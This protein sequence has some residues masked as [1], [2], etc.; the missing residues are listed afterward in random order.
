M[1]WWVG[2]YN[3]VWRELLVGKFLGQTALVLWEHLA[4]A[5]PFYFYF[6]LLGSSPPSFTPTLS[7]RID[8]TL[9]NRIPTT[10]LQYM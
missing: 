3:D 7:I 1:E 6:P 10:N 4:M 2:F 5:P 9:I 8:G